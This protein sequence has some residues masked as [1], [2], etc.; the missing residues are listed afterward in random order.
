MTPLAGREGGRCYGR[1]S[2]GVV[3]SD[4][5]GWPGLG[6]IWHYGSSFGLALAGLALLCGRGGRG[7]GQ[8]A[9][10]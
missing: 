9:G 8:G 4:R 2:T 6:W 10:Q 5:I 1:R 3:E 7:R